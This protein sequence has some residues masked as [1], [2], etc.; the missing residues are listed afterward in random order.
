[1]SFADI[2]RLFDF[3]GMEGKEGRSPHEFIAREFL[4]PWKEVERVDPNTKLKVKDYEID[5]DARTEINSPAAFAA[6]ESYFTYLHRRVKKRIPKWI[7]PDQTTA[8][9]YMERFKI[10]MISKER[11]GRQEA[12]EI[13]SAYFGSTKA[14]SSS[15]A[16]AKDILQK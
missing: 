6:S 3:K 1:M 14:F 2:E 15:E 5:V 7:R 8:E 9:I 12:K 4:Y 16:V 10:N 11:R 13:L